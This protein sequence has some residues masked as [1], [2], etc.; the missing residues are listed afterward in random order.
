MATNI[1]RDGRNRYI[2]VGENVK[3]GDL[4]VIGMFVGIALTDADEDGYATVE[5]SSNSIDAIL[6]VTA[7]DGTNDVDIGV[8]DKLYYKDGVINKDTSGKL[9]GGAL[10]PLEAGK[11]KNIEVKLVLWS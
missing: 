8:G 5:F 7:S 1:V 9:I 2:H 3:S 6:P 11:T 4:V 10:E